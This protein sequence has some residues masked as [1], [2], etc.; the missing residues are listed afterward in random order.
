M[1]ASLISP[2]GTVL[3]HRARSCTDAVSEPSAKP[4]RVR[5][6]I[7]ERESQQAAT[8]GALAQPQENTA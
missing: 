7:P 1:T 4:V 3:L 6:T 8:D 5:L 2:T